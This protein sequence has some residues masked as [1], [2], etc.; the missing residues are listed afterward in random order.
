MLTKGRETAGCSGDIFVY[1]TLVYSPNKGAFPLLV[2]EKDSKLDQDEEQVR[3]QAP[4]AAT[5]APGSD[6]DSS[7]EGWATYVNTPYLLHFPAKS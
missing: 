6:S 7:F 1:A 4:T 5:W 3:A 2:S